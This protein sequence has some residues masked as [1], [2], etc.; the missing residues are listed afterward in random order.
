MLVRL[1]IEF[2]NASCAAIKA[3]TLLPVG[4]ELRIVITILILLTDELYSHQVGQWFHIPRY[5]ARL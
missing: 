4:E 1:V 5:Q 3:T 2:H